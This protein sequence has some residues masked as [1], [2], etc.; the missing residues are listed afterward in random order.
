MTKA[1]TRAAIS[2]LGLVGQWRFAWGD[3]RITLPPGSLHH[4][5][6]VDDEL[7][8]DI[9]CYTDDDEDA[10]ATAKAMRHSF[11]VNPPPG[12]KSPWERRALV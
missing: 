7:R 1:E 2:A 5:K 9:A 11:E 6:K 8:E 12:F 3:W 10:L 4:I